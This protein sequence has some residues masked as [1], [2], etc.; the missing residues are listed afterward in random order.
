MCIFACIGGFLWWG[1][2]GAVAGTA[3]AG[4]VARTAGAV[5]RTAGLGTAAGMAG[6]VGV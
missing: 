4:A 3:E 6:S 5:A 2:V 1:M